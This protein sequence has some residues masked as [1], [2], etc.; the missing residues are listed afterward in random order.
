MPVHPLT[1]MS[2]A[3]QMFPKVLLRTQPAAATLQNSPVQFSPMSRLHFSRSRSDVRF[4]HYL[5]RFPAKFHPPVV[6]LLLNRYTKLGDLIL[7]PFCGSGTLLVEALT[8]GRHAVGVDIDPLATFISRVKATPIDPD[9]LQSAFSLLSEVI[10]EIRRPNEQYDRFMFDDISEST[11]ARSRRT[12]RIPEIPNISHWFRRYVIVDLARLKNAILDA[13]LSSGTRDFFL[14]CFASIIRNASNADPVPVSGLEVTAHMR[15]LDEEGRKID[16]FALFERRVR[17]QLIGMQ[18]LWDASKDSN[19]TVKRGDATQ[20]RKLIRKREFDALI[21]SPPYN[22]S[23]DYYRR[24]MLEMYW[25]DLVTSHEERLELAPRYL[26]RSNVRTDH[27]ALDTTFES[28][29]VNRLIA[30]AGKISEA[31]RRTIVHYCASLQSALSEMSVLLRRGGVAILVVGNAKWNGRRVWASR[32]VIE[33]SRPYF[34]VKDSYRY[35]SK[36]RYMSYSRHNGANVNWE[37]V[38]VLTKRP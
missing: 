20:L 3:R 17:R 21:T 10:Q 16:P 23:V 27:P 5:F 29:Y 8:L 33:L 25:L 19:I 35:A 2:P 37:H 32:L 22:T 6:R 34:T 28:S 14:A 1:H 4:T 13:P 12:L 7:D 24:H 31:R 15:R 30:H 18:Q 11:F 38:V 36:N 9:K 26:G